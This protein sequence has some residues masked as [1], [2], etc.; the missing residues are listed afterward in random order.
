[1]RNPENR[2][3]VT[4]IVHNHMNAATPMD[5]DKYI[6]SIERRKK[7]HGESEENDDISEEDHDSEK[8][9]YQDE[10]GG[11]T[12]FTGDSEGRW[13]TTGK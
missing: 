11:P 3:V 13:Q 5:V 8:D 6:T 2:D 9:G 7:S 1:M 10:E 12:C 4:K